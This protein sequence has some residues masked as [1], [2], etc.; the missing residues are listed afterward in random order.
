MRVVP[1]RETSTLP[2]SKEA[3]CWWLPSSTKWKE[4]GKRD[5]LSSRRNN[6]SL[7]LNFKSDLRIQL[8]ATESNKNHLKE[9]QLL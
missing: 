5:E 9:D 8:D 7:V 3:G 4:K 2:G 6:S 1:M